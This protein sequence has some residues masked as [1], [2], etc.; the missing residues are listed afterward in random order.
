[1]KT[2]FS[3]RERC[4]PCCTV[5]DLAT[6]L[7]PW[8]QGG[9]SACLA[10]PID[11]VSLADKQ[12]LTAQLL[13]S[14]API[15]AMNQVRKALSAVKGG[16]LATAAGQATVHSL[17]ISDVPGDNPAD[18]ASG[19][20]VVESGGAADALPILEQYGIVI[21]EHVR[22]A[23]MSYKETNRERLNDTV[24][25][26]AS[27]AQ[28]LDAMATLAR[29][30]GFEVVNLGDTIEGESA[31]IAQEHATRLLELAAQTER[32]TLVISGG[33][34]TVTL[35]QNCQGRGGRNTEYQLA[36]ALALGGHPRI[37]A[38]AGDSDGIDGVSDA[39]GAIVTP[40]TLER[41][42][43]AGINAAR[44][45]DEHVPY[46][47]FDQL[48]DLVITGPTRTNVND[49]R[50][51]L[52]TQGPDPRQQPAF[53]VAYAAGASSPLR[54]A[55]STIRVPSIQRLPA[56]RPRFRTGSLR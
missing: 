34:T 51:Q 43:R 8:F 46:D 39:A 14:G 11:G 36:M 29:T 10:L 38:L 42:E 5:P 54:P 17:V 12:A 18:V 32:P 19:P 6:W 50:I 25:V 37:W 21:P 56:A 4:W 3:Q 23:L 33:E 48:G 41:A 24:R 40:D 53:P 30:R 9:G 45:L 55:P 16:K 28:S 52:I 31:T 44:A 15:S 35:P 49:I 13:R 22:A 26:I 7:S 47:V 27:P 2:A 20:T 1:M